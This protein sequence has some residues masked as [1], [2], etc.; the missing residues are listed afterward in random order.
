M[1]KLEKFI[2][3]TPPV[4]YLSEKSKKIILPGFE[5]VPLYDVIVFFSSQMN[6]VG[7]NDRA[8]AIAFNFLMAIPAATIFLCTLIPFMPISREITIELL[9]LTKIFAPNE[10]TYKVVANFL[11]DFLN[12]PR[13][14]LLSLGFVLA[15]YYASNAV[16]GIMRS[17]NRS[18]VTVNKRTFFNERLIAIRLTTVLILLII[19]TISLLVTQGTIFRYL[20][21][22]LE[23][24]NSFVRWLI[25][26]IRW[27][28]V[29]LLVLY[30]IGFLYK[31][32]PAISKRWKLASPG[33]IFATALVIATTFV[34]SFWVTNFDSY[35]KV[36]G[37]IGTLLI[38]MFLIYINS[39]ILLIGYELNVS[40]HSLKALADE[41][42][43]HE[44]SGA[45]AE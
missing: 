26:S 30:S 23:I 36:Y 14:G 27:V 10:T 31:Y 9:D 3:A 29:I 33:A 22:W 4:K 45:V 41:R 6:K 25:H 19:A 15:V 40:I 44:T 18:L 21:N 5:K 13:S 43:K 2:L 35:N 17:F 8:A 24:T 39:L 37:S 34:F 7:L 28:I 32:A 11:N 38:L 42:E 20:M 1:T 12:K 16:L